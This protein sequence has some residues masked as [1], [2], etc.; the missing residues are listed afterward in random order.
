[1]TT[2]NRIIAEQ[3]IEIRLLKDKVNELECE[4]QIAKSAYNETMDSLKKS[5]KE[6]SRASEVEIVVNKI[7]SLK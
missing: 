1:M 2:E 6:S 7:D 4:L 5:R 3:A